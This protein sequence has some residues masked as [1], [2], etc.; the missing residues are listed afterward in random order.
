MCTSPETFLIRQ[1]PHKPKVQPEGMF[2]PDRFHPSEL[3]YRRMTGDEGYR[4]VLADCERA[5]GRPEVALRLVREA[6]AEDPDADEIV[7]LRLVEERVWERREAFLA[8]NPAGT[9]PVALCGGL[10]APYEPFV[11][12][13]VRERLRKPRAD[14]VAGALELARRA[15][16][17]PGTVA[18]T[19][20]RAAIK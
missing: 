10:A 13:P 15:S 5:L 6:L 8:L 18:R 14:S 1:V 7:E 12:A 2:S 16:W 4:A 19:G 9:L 3:G 20:G 11:P 17:S